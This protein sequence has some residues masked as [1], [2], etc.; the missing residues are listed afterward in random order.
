LIPGSTMATERNPL[1]A[2]AE[3]SPSGS[4]NVTGSQVKERNPSM[5]WMSSHTASTGMFLER[6]SSAI[7]RIFESGE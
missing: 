1:A 5:C 6:S 2:S 7:A 4:G 3:V